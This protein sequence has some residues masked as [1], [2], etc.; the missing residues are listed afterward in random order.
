[1]SVSTTDEDLSNVATTPAPTVLSH[2]LLLDSDSD[3]PQNSSMGPSH[4]SS[5]MHDGRGYRWQCKRQSTSSQLF[6]TSHRQSIIVSS[7]TNFSFIGYVSSIPDTSH[8]SSSF[9]S[10]FDAALQDYTNQTGTR[11][12]E[13]PFAIQFETCGSV[14]SISSTLQQHAQAFCGFRGEDGKLIKSLRSTVHILYTLSISAVLG[15][16]IGLVCTKP[17]IASVCP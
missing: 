12:D 15:E 17:L 5:R 10:L 6:T 16:G 13:H 9:R 8:A 2:R 14:E 3:C 4:S 7:K 1:M 11:L